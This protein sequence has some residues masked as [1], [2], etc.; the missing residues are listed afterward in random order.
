MQQDFSTFYRLVIEDDE[1]EFTA[2]LSPSA[3]KLDLDVNFYERGLY[4][5]APF[6]AKAIRTAWA[7]VSTS[8]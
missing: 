3:C 2:M 1:G 8:L 7:Y 5:R 6:T 4:P